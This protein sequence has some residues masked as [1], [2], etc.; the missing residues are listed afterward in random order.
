MFCS[1]TGT[2][3][4]T[5]APVA[6]WGSLQTQLASFALSQPAEA[7]SFL[8]QTQQIHCYFPQK[9][10]TV[11]KSQMFLKSQPNKCSS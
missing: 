7:H 4:E 6:H 9:G 11:L 10:D 3:Q 1:F 8:Q 5:T 2:V